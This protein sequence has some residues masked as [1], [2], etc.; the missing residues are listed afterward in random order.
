MSTSQFT[1]PID[2]SNLSMTFDY[3]NLI[4]Y[5]TSF[6]THYLTSYVNNGDVFS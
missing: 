4:Q 1:D 2:F 3:S 6:R 5:Y